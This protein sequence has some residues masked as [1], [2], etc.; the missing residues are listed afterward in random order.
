MVA[1]DEWPSVMIAAATGG[2]TEEQILKTVHHKTGDE[3]D[4]A[5]S[6]AYFF[7]GQINLVNNNKLKAAVYLQ[8]SIDKGILSNNLQTPARADLERLHR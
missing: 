1:Q 8:R 3:L 7:I 5:L 6:E 4:S 2:K